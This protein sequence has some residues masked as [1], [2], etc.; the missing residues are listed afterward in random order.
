MLINELHY[1]RIHTHTFV[2]FRFLDNKGLLIFVNGHL[3][4][5]DEYREVQN[6]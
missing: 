6:K 4:N 3:T 2:I 5:D 1:T